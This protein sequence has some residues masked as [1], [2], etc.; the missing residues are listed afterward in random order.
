MTVLLFEYG[1]SKIN[2]WDRKWSGEGKVF[3]KEVFL[4]TKKREKLIELGFDLHRGAKKTFTY[5]FGD[6]WVA[7][8][9]IDRGRVYNLDI[10]I[11]EETI[12]S[13]DRGWEIYPETAEQEGILEEVLNILT[14]N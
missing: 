5:D 12:V 10:S 2:T 3:A 14:E 9:G 1:H 8:D 13:Y 4:T 7:K 6:G 11:G